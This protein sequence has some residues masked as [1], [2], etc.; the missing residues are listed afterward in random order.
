MIRINATPG[1]LRHF[2]LSW[3]Q[4]C[5]E[6]MSDL[7]LIGGKEV[8]DEMVAILYGKIVEDTEISGFFEGA[9]ADRLKAH[10]SDFFVRM[11]DDQ[12]N[13]AE[14]YL[15]R[16]H[17]PLVDRGL[18][19]DHFDAFYSELQHTMAEIGVPGGLLHTTL[20]RLEDYREA[21]LNR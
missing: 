17:K 9:D 11:L 18:N 16:I 14:D 6:N 10:L 15:R 19:D 1:G 20:E 21:L 13:D 8:V 5:G 2:Q 3:R 7:E 12:A 4:D